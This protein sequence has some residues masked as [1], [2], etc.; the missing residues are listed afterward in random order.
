MSRALRELER[1]EH[2]VLG[3]LRFVD[4][5]TGRER[6]GPLEL[7]AVEGTARFVRSRSGLQVLWD[8][9]GL[10]EHA[11][12]FTAPPGAP[13]TGS[14][15][16]RFEVRDP[17]GEYLPRRASLDLP[18]NPDPDLAHD[19][20]SL[21]Q[22]A[23]VPLYRA[24]AAPTGPNWAVIRATVTD[25]A[26]GARLGGAVLTV[27]R[28]ER[29]IARGLTDGRGEGVVPVVGIPMLTFGAEPDPDDEEDDGAVVVDSVAVRLRAAFSSAA[30]TRMTEEALRSGRRP[31]TPTVDP[32]AVEA[33]E[34]SAR[35]E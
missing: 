3:A 4:A 6:L 2:R 30:G 23:T 25:A 32:D 1:I 9:S 11:S 31:P 22:P 19:P 14:V 18:R 35:T 20:D 8:W 16:F 27:T 28:G 13:P 29:V 17:T 26:S 5:A 7:S 15:P 10:R 33:D 34:D 12:A 24:P 21:F